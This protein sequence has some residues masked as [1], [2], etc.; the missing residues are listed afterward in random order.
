M[1]REDLGARLRDAIDDVTHGKDTLALTREPLP[2][3]DQNAMTFAE[4]WEAVLD[5]LWA[6]WE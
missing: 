3:V 6:Q 5:S 2:H 4:F 1:T